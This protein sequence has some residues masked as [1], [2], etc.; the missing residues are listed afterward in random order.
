MGAV[1]I[2]DQSAKPYPSILR[3]KHGPSEF[4]NAGVLYMN[5]VE[6]LVAVMDDC[7][8]FNYSNL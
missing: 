1:L 3:M 8:R 5:P 4:R 6:S 7:F 2:T